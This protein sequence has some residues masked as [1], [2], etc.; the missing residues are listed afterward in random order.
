MS[1]RSKDRDNVAMR[2]Y[3]LY[4]E[5]SFATLESA[6]EHQLSL[7]VAGLEALVAPDLEEDETLPDL[8]FLVELLVRGLRRRL[9]WLRSAELRLDDERRRGRPLRQQ[10]R[11]AIAALRKKLAVLKITFKAS[12]GKQTTRQLTGL[13]GQLPRDATALF[14]EAMDAL[15][16]LGKSGLK[17]SPLK[18]RAVRH[19]PEAWLEHFRHETEALGELAARVRE[20]TRATELALVGK[21]HALDDYDQ[22][23]FKLALLLE[24][25]FLLSGNDELAR[26]IRPSRQ[27]KGRLLDELR[28]PRSRQDAAAEPTSADAT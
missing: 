26:K 4:R 24:A 3:L 2:K 9:T 6:V 11:A 16:R 1:R 25:L 27:K 17:L 19:D 23:F 7:V 20:N 15:S 10:L 12:F 22:V 21:D 5:K 14:R 18:L 8:R 28:H 13:K